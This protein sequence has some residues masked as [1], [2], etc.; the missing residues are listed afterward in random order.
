MGSVR[1]VVILKFI[2]LE[3]VCPFLLL[4]RDPALYDDT[5]LQSWRARDTVTLFS[6]CPAPSVR[7]LSPRVQMAEGH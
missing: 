5:I 3:E 2:A 7:V 6:P 4:Y 1:S